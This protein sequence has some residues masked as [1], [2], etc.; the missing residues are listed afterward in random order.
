MG[1]YYWILNVAVPPSL[2]NSTEP[3]D[4]DGKLKTDAQILAII[5]VSAI[6]LMAAVLPCLIWSLFGVKGKFYI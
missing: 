2:R 3:E 1:F 6:V 5:A 4:E